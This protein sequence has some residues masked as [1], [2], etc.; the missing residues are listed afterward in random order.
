MATLKQETHDDDQ[1]QLKVTPKHRM[2]LIHSSSPVA[3]HRGE[4]SSNSVENKGNNKTVR[5][6]STEEL[7]WHHA[8]LYQLYGQQADYFL[9]PK[10]QQPLP[11]K[12]SN[13]KLRNQKGEQEGCLG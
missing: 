9:H 7:P 2:P 10:P 11:V 6:R 4:R 3:E 13:P 1:V 5:E 12:Q 8:Q